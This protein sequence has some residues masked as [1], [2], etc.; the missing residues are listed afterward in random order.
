MGFPGLQHVQGQDRFKLTSV[1]KLMC[2]VK[3][4]DAN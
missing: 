1:H 2:V 4:A 3:V